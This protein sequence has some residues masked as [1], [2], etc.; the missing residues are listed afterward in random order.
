MV[1]D[2]WA[3][4]QSNRLNQLDVLKEQLFFWLSYNIMLNISVKPVLRKISLLW[5][6]NFEI[7]FSFNCCKGNKMIGRT[8]LFI[9]IVTF[10]FIGEYHLII[11]SPLFYIFVTFQ[12]VSHL[13]EQNKTI[14]SW[15]C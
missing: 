7:I 12:T 1:D 15:F 11:F 13:A 5:Y 3:G 9:L 6:V 10:L 14:E 2:A 8:S 4:F